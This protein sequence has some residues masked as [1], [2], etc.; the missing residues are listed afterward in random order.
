MFSK[1][2][3]QIALFAG[4]ALVVFYAYEQKIIFSEKKN[5]KVIINGHAFSVEIADSDQ[6]RKS[7]LGQK[8]NLCSDCG[9]LFEFPSSG[10]YNFWMKDMRFPLDIIWISNNKIVWLEKNVPAEYDQTLSPQVEAQQVLEIN[11]GKVDEFRISL[12]DIVF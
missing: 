4:L 2:N 3:I 11:A 5:D 7:G 12:G 1:R 10:R 9:M 6:E 8:K